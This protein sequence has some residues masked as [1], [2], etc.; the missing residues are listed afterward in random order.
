[1]RNYVENGSFRYDLMALIPL[2]ILYL[3]FGVECTLLRLP[4]ILKMGDFM[5]FFRRLGEFLCEPGVK[6]NIKGT[7]SS[8]YKGIKPGAP[9]YLDRRLLE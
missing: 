9:Q 1:M 3:K 5:E 6:F 7:L 2:D 8:C 4:R